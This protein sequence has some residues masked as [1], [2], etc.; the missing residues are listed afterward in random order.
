MSENLTAWLLFNGFVAVMLALD[1]GIFNRKSHIVSVREALSWTGVWML[2]AFAFDA[3]IYFWRGPGAAMEFLTGYL[4][5]Q[6]L[7]ID[8]I[9]VFILVFAYFRVPKEF[10]HKILFWGILGA[11]VMRATFILVGIELIEHFHW[12]TYILGGFLVFTGLKMI[13]HEDQDIHP[14]HNPVLKILRRIVPISND[15]DGS[16][17]FTTINLKKYA[18]PMLV[19]LLIVETTDVIFATD[20]IP[21]ILAI[22]T[23][24]FIV[25][26]SNVFAILGL[27][28]LYFAMAAILPM[29]RYLHFGL[30]AILSFVGLKMVFADIYSLSTPIALG[31]VGGIL[32][33]ALIASRMNP[34]RDELLP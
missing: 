22:T 13:K 11:L 8:N 28:S 14:E 25:Y 6:A 17:F 30:A 33:I 7:S 20:S 32:L 34:I 24:A 21:A 16:R 4:I 12:V 10:Q 19:V 1:L 15:Y 2:L 26:T 18:T 3:M 9:F 31:V 27:R 29:F 5:E 23:N